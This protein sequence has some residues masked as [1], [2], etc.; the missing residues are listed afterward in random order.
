MIT[1]GSFLMSNRLPEKLS[2]LRKH[3]S[4][5][6]ADV[7][8]K[9][10]VPVQEYMKWENGN[11]LCDII[12]LKKL[13]DFYSIPIRSLLDNTKEVELPELGTTYSTV[14]IPFK[15]KI[16]QG[17]MKAPSYQNAT[18]VEL[19]A[20]QF[21]PQVQKP[22]TQDTIEHTRLINKDEFEETIAQRIIDDEPTVEKTSIKESILSKLS[23]RTGLYVGG[24]LLA[25]ILLFLGFNWLRNRGGSVNNAL[26]KTNRVVLADRYSIYIDDTGSLVTSGEVPSLADF[27]NVVQISSSGSGLLGLKKDGSVVCT[28]SGTACEVND[29]KNIKMIAAGTQHSVGLKENGEVVCVGADR[30]CA[31]KEWKDIEAVYAGNGIT[32]GKTKEGK[33]LIAGKVSSQ[34]SLEEAEKV[35]DVSIGENQIVVVYEDGRVLCYGIEGNVV[36][37]TGNWTNITRAVSGTNYA[38]GLTQS[39]TV[40]STT[41]NN[42]MKEEIEKWKDIQ[43][44]AARGNTIIAIKNGKIIGVG[45]NTYKQYGTEEEVEPSDNPDSKLGKVSNI[46]FTPTKAG[47]SIQWDAVQNASYYEITVNTSPVTKIN[48][49]KNSASIGSNQLSSGSTY[50]FTFTPYPSDTSKY[51]AGETVTMEYKYEASLLQLEK[52]QN[53]VAKQNGNQLNVT[54]N[55]VQNADYYNV[56]IESLVQAANGTSH[57]LDASSMENG[58][59]Y[60]IYVT[61]MSNNTSKYSESEAGTT[62]FTYQAP[63]IVQ[64]L[65]QPS[66]NVYREDEETHNL[67]IELNTVENADHYELTINKKT[68]QSDVEKGTVFTIPASDLSVGSYSVTIRAIPSDTKMY[69]PSESTRD[70]PYTYDG[71]S[72]SDDSGETDDPEEGKENG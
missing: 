12:Y 48:A 53:V 65:A 42:E 25:L 26:T 34:T 19:E 59:T 58:K 8:E 57:T 43:Y 15:D 60:T 72:G 9:I 44:I 71:N 6:L 63:V 30:A 17:E 45:D 24:A 14:D 16:N 67:I 18:M 64:P 70:I 55:P 39:G 36:A 10:E 68:Y 20:P 4:Y 27:N 69:S 28:G 22:V 37:N 61:A 21:E 46:R 29:W 38:V 52:P 47:L 51:E 62:T 32:I 23:W 7:A 54:W 50:T 3:Y 31:V 41:T 1:G 33:L 11:K 35:K 13:A 66:V 2:T 49:A 5:S 40:V 56:A